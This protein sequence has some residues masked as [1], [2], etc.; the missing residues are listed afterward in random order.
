MFN[1][2]NLGELRS[3]RASKGKDGG[4]LE[5]VKDGSLRRENCNEAIQ[6]IL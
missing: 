5:D 3:E 6:N 1:S 4:I 2:A